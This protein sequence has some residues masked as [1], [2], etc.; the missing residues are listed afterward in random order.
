MR[1]KLRL[2]LLILSGLLLIGAIIP[3]VLIM[4][5]ESCATEPTVT[6]T[7]P[8]SS[9]TTTSST[10]ATA[11]VSTTPPTTSIP[12]TETVAVTTVPP[13]TVPPTTIPPETT[14]PPTT[15]PPATTAPTAD[16]NEYIGSLYTRAYL[17]TLDSTSKGYGAGN[18]VDGKNRPTYAMQLTEKFK[19]FDAHF[20]MPD[21]GKIYLSF[22]CGYE[23][24]NLTTVFLDV[25]KEKDVKVVF[26]V[27]HYFVKSNPALI[28]RIID[29]GHILANHCTNHPDLP[30]QSIDR[31]VYEIMTIHNYV[32]DTYGYEM[33]LF[34]PPSGYYSEQVLAIAQSLGYRTYNFSF[35]YRDW[36]E[37]NLPDPAETLNKLIA[38][39]HSGAI[40][41]LHTVSGTNAAIIGPF[42]DAM[43]EQ[44]Y[45]FALLP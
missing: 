15:A 12:P 1:F 43:R 39:A 33:K 36:D 22:N 13:E 29:D 40:Y 31:I 30:R 19:H 41:Q 2:V 37:V 23:Y 4:H 28:Q 42:I 11:T 27:N 38:K 8:Q 32:L 44:G 45:E 25:L 7:Q 9:V 21:D 24:N 5:R 6:S 34:R 26:F 35:S 17:Q 18:S 16:P 10:G 14:V 3:L 20:I